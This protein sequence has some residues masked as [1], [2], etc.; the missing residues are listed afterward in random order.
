MEGGYLRGRGWKE[1]KKK[2][3]GEK[4]RGT[5]KQTDRLW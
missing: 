2:K 1:E 4:N 3:K 5:V